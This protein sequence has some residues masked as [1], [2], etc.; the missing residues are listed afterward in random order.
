MSTKFHT[1]T[2]KEVIPETKDAVSLIFDVPTDLKEDY[3]FTQGQYLTLKLNINGEEVRRA[4]SMSSSPLE[5]VLKVTIKRIEGGL[6]SNYINDNVKAGSQLEVMQPQGRFF[7]DLDGG[8]RKSYLL[9]S[10]GSG[11]TPMMSIIKTIVEVEPMSD[12][13]LFYGNKDEE[14]IIFKNELDQLEDKYAGQLKVVHI[15]SHP[16]REKG[17]LFRKGK[18]NWK[19]WIGIPDKKNTKKFLDEHKPTNRDVEYFICG[20]GPMMDTVEAVL[21]KRHISKKNIH[22]ERFSSAKLPHEGGGGA[23]AQVIVHLNGNRHEIE[24]KSGEAILDALLRLKL[25][26]PYSCTAGACSTCM[27]KLSQGKVEMEVC[28]ALDDDEIE[29]GFI[30]TCQSRPTTPV[31]ELSYD[32]V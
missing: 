4:Y 31:V 17:G 8:Q 30:L 26:P 13:T 7:T 1:L 14:S 19:G 2:V 12:I 5:D 11:I 23:D 25:D 10:G 9:F 21:K 28:F 18:T 29:D 6:V 24:L 20:P 3:K 32:D 22:I 27:A 15:L 16:S